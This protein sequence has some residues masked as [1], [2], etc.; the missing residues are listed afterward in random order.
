MDKVFEQAYAKIEEG[1]PARLVA[2]K[3]GLDYRELFKLERKRKKRVNDNFDNFCEW[4]IKNESDGFKTEF[5]SIMR[6]ADYK[7]SH[8]S[9]IP[10]Y[11][12]IS[13]Y[14]FLKH[15]EN[16]KNRLEDLYSNFG[17]SEPTW[18]RYKKEILKVV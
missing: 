18:R 11:W 14:I 4:L 6:K 17:I 15:K 10:Q 3:M 8:T 13:I 7:K 2:Y 9:I 12:F 16:K 5:Q 1:F